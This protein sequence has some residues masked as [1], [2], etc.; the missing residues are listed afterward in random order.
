MNVTF[1]SVDETLPRVVF[2]ENYFT[3]HKKVLYYIV[4]DT[5]AFIYF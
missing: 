5:W 1:Y 3:L 2:A 4:G